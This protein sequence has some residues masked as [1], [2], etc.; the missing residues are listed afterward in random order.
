MTEQRDRFDKFGVD[1]EDLIFESDTP[2]TKDS[3]TKE[4]TDATDA[5]PE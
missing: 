4:T 2:A 3:K 5:E 1:E